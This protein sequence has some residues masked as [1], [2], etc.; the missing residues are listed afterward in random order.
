VFLPVQA[1]SGR[2]AGLASLPLRFTAIVSQQ[3]LRQSWKVNALTW[4]TFNI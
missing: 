1:T 3:R 2:E 4:F